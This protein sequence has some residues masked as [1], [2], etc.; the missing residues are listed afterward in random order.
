[1][2]ESQYIPISMM[3]KVDALP[4]AHKPPTFRHI[5]SHMPSNA[6]E[7]SGVEQVGVSSD[8]RFKARLIVGK[9]GTS[10]ARSSST[11]RCES[12][13][14]VQWGWRSVSASLLLYERFA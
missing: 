13:R 11:T 7:K 1:M 5:A 14:D 12:V 6:R 2:L 4:P 3:R 9:C 8:R 10:T